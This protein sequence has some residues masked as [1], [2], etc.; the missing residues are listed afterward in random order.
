MQVGAV[1]TQ[2]F[3]Y[4]TNQVTSASLN[5]V[6]PVTSDVNAERTDFS[7]LARTNENPLRPGESADF[8]SIYEEQMSRSELNAARVM[9]NEETEEDDTTE[10]AANVRED[11]VDDTTQATVASSQQEETNV[12]N[13]VPGQQDMAVEMAAQVNNT[14]AAAETIERPE[15]AERE[16]VETNNPQT[17]TATVT[18]DGNVSTFNREAVAPNQLQNFELGAS[19][20]EAPVS[21]N[22]RTGGTVFSNVIP[23]GLERPFTN[24]AIDYAEARAEEPTL[25]DR[26]QEANQTAQV[27]NEPN[28]PNNIYQMQRATQAYAMAMGM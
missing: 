19:A 20:V 16:P 4:N 11:R 10:T 1:G 25:A 17:V 3:I 18:D 12:N 6:R 2:P 23:D 27:A 22:E 7:D 14:Y 9:R 5:K 8:A 15:P 21:G 28:E 13:I 24:V 26:L